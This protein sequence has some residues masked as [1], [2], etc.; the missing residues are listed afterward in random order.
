MR[1]SLRVKT[2]ISI[3]NDL[4]VLCVHHGKMENMNKVTV[5]DSQAGIGE[6][7]NINQESMPSIQ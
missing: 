2:Q 5:W 4:Q 6:A 3:E 1:R 7:W